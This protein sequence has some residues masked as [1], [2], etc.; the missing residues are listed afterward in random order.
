MTADLSFDQ[1]LKKVCPQRNLDWR[2]YRRASRRRVLA[3]IRELGLKGYSEY[4][5]YL[6]RDPEESANLPNLLRVTVS[7]F[8]RE[9]EVWQDLAATVL[10]FLLFRKREASPL[11]VLSI[12]CCNGEEPYS[13]A[14]L[15]KSGLDAEFPDASIYITGVDVDADVLERAAQGIYSRKTLREVPENMLNNWFEPVKQEYR[16]DDE[17]RRMVDFRHLD[18]LENPLPEKQDLILCRYLAF[19]YFHGRL[20]RRAI[21]RI[22]MVL[23]PHG[24]LVLGGKEE[25]GPEGESV[26]MPVSGAVHVYR[27]IKN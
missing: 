27:K 14:L 4:A 23:E 15:W 18:F 24:F 1:F 21:D 12:G 25:P 26:I 13:V 16:L 10:P 17:V 5:E 2:K 7:R 9:R 19:T 22:R 6:D 8:F 3:R 11:R 20:L